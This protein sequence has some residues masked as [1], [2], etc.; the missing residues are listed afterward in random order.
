[1]TLLLVAAGFLGF[2]WL[3]QMLV[4]KNM[5]DG[6]QHSN[7]TGHP[8]RRSSNGTYNAIAGRRVLPTE[9][10]SVLLASCGER[11]VGTAEQHDNDRSRA[12]PEHLVAPPTCS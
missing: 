4:R 5:E 9:R 2:L 7:D 8:L 1:M 11:V 3:T 12:P 10:R 6:S